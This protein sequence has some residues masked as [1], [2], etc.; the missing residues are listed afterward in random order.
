[1][2]GPPRRDWGHCNAAPRGPP[3]ALVPAAPLCYPH[4]PPPDT[5][6]RTVDTMS[7]LLVGTGF[8]GALTLLFLLRLPYRMYAQLTEHVVHFSPKGGC[9][10]AIVKEVKQARHEILVMAY[11]FTSDPVWQA[12]AEAKL[13]GVQ[14]EIIL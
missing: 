1:M 3:A 14:V 6:V 13:R 5:E 10:D 9:T 11:S 4:R 8:T 7:W 2:G 12:L